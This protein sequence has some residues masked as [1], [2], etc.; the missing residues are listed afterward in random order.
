MAV[1]GAHRAMC[2]PALEN[3]AI[4]SSGLVA[5]TAP[6][7]ERWETKSFA[8]SDLEVVEGLAQFYT[9]VVCTRLEQR[10]PA[11]SAAYRALL[12]TQSVPYK[13]HL[14]WVGDD[15]RGGEIMRVS[16]IE[17]RSRGT[18]TLSAFSEALKRYRLGVRGRTQ[19]LFDV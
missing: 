5:P 17:C 4:R 16:M 9:Q 11:A 15:E 8:G 13:I 3:Q 6:D 19:Q 14:D 18:T 2:A 10:M 12:K 7:N 1:P